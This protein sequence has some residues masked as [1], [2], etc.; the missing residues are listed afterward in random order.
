MAKEKE[1][2][3]SEA[4]EGKAAKPKAESSNKLFVM[5][6]A[7]VMIIQLVIIIVAVF[8]IF[9]KNSG[10]GDSKPKKD[11]TEKVEGE[12]EGEDKKDAKKEETEK[13]NEKTLPPFMT[14]DL[15]INPKGTG[16]KRFLMTQ[17]GIYLKAEN[18]KDK[19]ELEKKW[20][21][22][23]NSVINQYLSGK[24]VDELDDL[25]MRDSMAIEIKGK[26]NEQIPGKKVLKIVFS[27]FAIQ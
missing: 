11:G 17:I 26:I 15:I 25:K 20:E 6:F 5:M 9:N 16:G 23:F 3:K 27:K 4:V 13:L 21:A 10:G 14:K 24:T 2:K 18:D 1:P 12:G 7:G 22:Q 19:E 8:F